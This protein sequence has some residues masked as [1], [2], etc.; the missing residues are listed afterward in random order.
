M[1]QA[2]AMK[3][4]LHLARRLVDAIEA[5]DQTR[6][7][8]AIEALSNG[9]FNALF[10][11]IGKLTRALH[12]TFG[13]LAADERLISFARQSMPDAR[14]RLLYVIE[15]TEEAANR[16]LTAVE[17]MI[18]MSDRMVERAQRLQAELMDLHDAEATCSQTGV[19][20]NSIV[21]DGHVLRS[22]LTD[23]LMA[24]EYQD[25]TSQVIKRTIAL[26]SEVEV[27]LVDLV[28]ACG[29][30]AGGSVAP[31]VESA[32]QS[33]GPVISSNAE[34][35]SRQADVDELLANLGF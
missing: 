15:K 26:V 9:R 13:S 33:R 10:N 23:V 20:L 18:P 7:D 2:V 31:R 34:S 32:S 4:N 22:G 5:G 28:S 17:T 16:T 25:L 14:A 27:K 11:E 3:D 8:D 6:T 30:A 19:F 24:Q 29:A 12:D 1:S 35:V 21:N